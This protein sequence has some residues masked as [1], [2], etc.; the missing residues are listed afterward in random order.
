MNRSLEEL[1]VESGRES[2]RS[3]EGN[4]PTMSGYTVRETLKAVCAVTRNASNSR[5]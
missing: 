4:P 3:G 1:N 2:K 5:K